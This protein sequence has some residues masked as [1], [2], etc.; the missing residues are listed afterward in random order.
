MLGFEG[1]Q[2]LLFRRLRFTFRALEDISFA[3]GS[4][5]NTIRGAMGN[6]L[7][8][9]ACNPKCVSA[10]DCEDSKVCAYARIFEPRAALGPSG[11]GDVPRPFVIRAAHLDAGFVEKG[12]TF[13]FFLNIFDTDQS[14]EQVLAEAYER[15]GVSGRAVLTEAVGVDWDGQACAGPLAI[16]LAAIPSDRVRVHFVTPVELKGWTD[17]ERPEFGVLFARARDRCGTLRALYGDGPLSIDFRELGER[18]RA[19]HLIDSRMMPVEAERRSSRTG[20]RHSIG[21]WTGWA[22]YAGEMG[23]F[24]PFIAAGKWTGVGRHTAWGNG[25]IHLKF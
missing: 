14:L 2:S 11:F 6:I 10:R 18:S 8:S 17:P 19:V 21:G 15:W 13:S 5:G 22:E 1:L 7:R 25:E 12:K 24:L 16:P 4:V 23:D 3:P 9:I 20:Q